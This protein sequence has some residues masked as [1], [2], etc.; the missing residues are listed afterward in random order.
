MQRNAASAPDGPG[1]D[2][3]LR[4]WGAPPILAP[5]PGAKSQQQQPMQPAA[6]GATAV[7]ERSGSF[8]STSDGGAMGARWVVFRW[9]EGGYAMWQHGA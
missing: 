7:P 8:K 3:S 2:P 5:S 4:A 6:D 9:G 1:S